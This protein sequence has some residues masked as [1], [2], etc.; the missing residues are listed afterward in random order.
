MQQQAFEKIKQQLSCNPV[1]AIYDPQKQTTLA[2]DESSY[3]L[4]T[5]ITQI[6][7]DG[8]CRTIAYASQAL[9]STEE[10][11]IQIEEEL[12]ALTW[13]CECFSDYFIGKQFH[14]L[15][16]HK[17]LISLLSSKPLDTL[18]LRVQHFR[19]RLMRF[20]YI[21]SHVPGKE[22]TVLDTLTTAPVSLPTADDI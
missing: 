15:T 10:M 16:D 21:I 13:A 7:S 22:L 1:L 19:M 6:Q 20:T 3:G 11:Y 8:S 5:V 4:G 12:L 18:P 2:A 17:P 14:I 9:T